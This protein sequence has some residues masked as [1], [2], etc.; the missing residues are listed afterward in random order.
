[1]NGLK[2][3]DSL[4]LSL[5]VYS[6]AVSSSN[7]SYLNQAAAMFKVFKSEVPPIPDSLSPEGR[8][9][10]QC[11]LCRNPAQRPKASQLLEHLF[12][13]SATQQD[14]SD[15]LASAT[16][17]IKCLV[18]FDIS[19]L[20]GQA[21]LKYIFFCLFLYLEIYLMLFNVLQSVVHSPREKNINAFDSTGMSPILHSGNGKQHQPLRLHFWH[22]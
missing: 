21:V 4:K 19:K 10:V 7:N 22:I 6:F 5:V 16:S 3:L 13:R 17:S 14:S 15:L 9:F 8:H 11:C 1:V 20:Q 18:N 12:V 2:V